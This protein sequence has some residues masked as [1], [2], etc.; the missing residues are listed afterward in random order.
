[1]ILFRRKSF[2]EYLLFCTLF[3]SG[4]SAQLNIQ[5]KGRDLFIH[6]ATVMTVTNGTLEK[7]AIWIQNGKIKA[8]G[9]NLAVPADT[10]V[11]DGTGRFVIPGIID[12]HSHMGIEGGINES[13]RTVTPE[14]NIQDV[15]RHD[16]ISFQ[17]ALAGGVTAINTLHG[18]A[19]PIGG[20]NAVIKLKFGKPAEELFIPGAMQGIKFALGEN[21][22]RS[23]IGNRSARRFPASRMGVAFTLRDAFTQAKEYMRRWEEYELK[24]KGKIKQSP[25]EKKLKPIPP[26]RD[27]KL[28]ALAEILRGETE[29]ICHAYRMDEMLMLM[30]LGDELGFRVNSFEHCLEG[31]KIAD[32]L[33]KH[34]VIASIFA[35]MWAYKMEAFDAIP[36]NAALLTERG[37]VVTINSDSDERVRRLYQEAAKTMKYGNMS[38]TEALKTITLNPAKMLQIDH[39][40]GSIEIGKDAD[41]AIFNGHPFSVYSKVEMTIIEGEI[42][43]DLSETK[44][45]EKVLA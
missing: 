17:R 31:Y 45:T 6:S 44:T 9:S 5:G 18:S 1:M 38:E 32:E 43:F 42:Y 35:D 23:N 26:R 29:I 22:K 10:R 25:W 2:I 40:V 7:G 41:L 39:R 19:N 16:D 27:L 34:G 33:A 15:I 3:V 24:K 28:E 36:Y 37:V 4:V 21:P 30:E 8:V 11:I 14:V 12:S 20:R 13:S